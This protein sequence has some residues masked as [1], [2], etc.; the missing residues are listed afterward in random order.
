MSK[1]GVIFKR[2]GCR[3]NNRRRLEQSCPR[4][5]ERGHGT[6][7][8]HCS[9]T[10]LLG[11]RERARRGGYP[12]Q[13][14]ARQ[15]RDAWLTGTAGDRTAQGWTVERWL[16]HWLDTRTS[17]RPTTRFHYT[18]DVDI[19]LVPCLGG[20]RLA[21]LDAGLLRTVFAS[22]AATTNSKGR[23]QSASAMQHLRTTLRAALNLAVKEGV[24]YPSTVDRFVLG[25]SKTR[26]SRQTSHVP[27][28]SARKASIVWWP[29]PIR[30]DCRA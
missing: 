25:A 12:S 24:D 28:A 1:T 10:N 11:R 7:Y 8:F 26:R 29:S 17:I 22:I 3:D 5:A 23:P 16:R 18:R 15:A 6:W 27:V 13:A 21:D 4:L 20:Y 14:A 2:C 30:T 19:V 9:A